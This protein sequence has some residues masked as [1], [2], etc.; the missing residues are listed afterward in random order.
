MKKQDLGKLRDQSVTEL[1]AQA[2]KLTKELA[3]L[4]LEFATGKLKDMK[5][6]SRKRRDIAQLKTVLG[7]RNLEEVISGSK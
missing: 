6:M 3:Q 7:E 4:R 2:E 5:A 1:K